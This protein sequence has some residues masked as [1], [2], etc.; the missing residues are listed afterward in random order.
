MDVIFP[1]LHLRAMTPREQITVLQ[2]RIQRRLTELKEKPAP[3]AKRFNLGESFIRDILRKGVMPHASNMEKLAAALQTTSQYLL[4]L[5]DEHSTVTNAVKMTKIVGRAGAATD[6]AVLYSQ[7]DEG[8][9][10][11]M[12]PPGAPEESVA[13]E[14]EGYSM[15][16]L[17][18]GALI[19][20]S[21]QLPAPTDDMLGMIVVVGLKN[22]AVLLKR[23]LRGS[24]PGLYDLESINGPT[25]RDQRIDWAAHIDS[26]VPP[27]R[28]RRLRVESEDVRF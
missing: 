28:A 18:D 14:I 2:E 4:G 10:Y 13:V 20:Y 17:A 8:L 16:F 21:E 11:V 1:G 7:A 6:G 25:L 26:L 19:F 12:L 15:G 23:L 3:L 24:R 27:W 22:G 9:G 5:T